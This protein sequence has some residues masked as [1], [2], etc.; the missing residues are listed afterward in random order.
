M[1]NAVR[2]SDAGAIEVT[3]AVDINN[4]SVVIDDDGVGLGNPARRSGLANMEQRAGILNGTFTVESSGG[5]GTHLT[6]S[7]PVEEAQV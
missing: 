6:W 7:V 5:E 2:H 1:S 4:V 3:V